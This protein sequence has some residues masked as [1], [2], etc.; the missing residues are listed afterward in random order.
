M[1][2]TTFESA[3]SPLGV[4]GFLSGYWNRNFLLQKGQANRY[5][6][7]LPWVEL[8]RIL[9]MEPASIRIAKDG[10]MVPEHAYSTVRSKTRNEYRYA[11]L[12]GLLRDGA[13]LIVNN[14]DRMHSPIRT[15]AADFERVF[16]EFLQINLY[17]GWGTTQGF[18]LHWDDHDVFI[19]HLHGRKAWKV[20]GQSR[21]WPVTK[22]RDAGRKFDPP[23]A[24]VWE[25][26]LEPGDLLY[27]PRGWWHVASALAEP[28][29]H[30]TFGVK[31]RTGI[32][33]VSWLI[34]VL[35]L[36]EIFRKDFPRFGSDAEMRAHVDQLRTTMMNLFSAD[37][38]ENYLKEYTASARPKALFALPWQATKSIIPEVSDLRITTLNAR[39]LVFVAGDDGHFSFRMSGRT[40]RFPLAARPVVERIFQNGSCTLTE[41]RTAIP[42]VP[43][44]SA[45]QIL[46]DLAEKGVVSVQP[47]E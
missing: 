17:A 11:E 4:E 7:L 29:A 5:S 44:A 1:Q 45:R 46:R 27:M 31:N 12:M 13:T 6:Q 43:E 18:D 38:V 25:G 21:T 8:N 28:T 40:H 32:D 2:T 16:G 37:T 36:H 15:L 41:L 26:M 34:D 3:I 47:V 39:D 35:P 14:I 22:D 23:S 20:Y 10:N 42:E 19:L 24:P 30:L 33:F 9:S